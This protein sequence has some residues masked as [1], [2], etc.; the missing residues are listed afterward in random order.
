MHVSMRHFSKNDV[1]LIEGAQNLL[2]GDVARCHLGKMY[3]HVAPAPKLHERCMNL[4]MLYL[5]PT[6]HLT[7]SCSTTCS[8]PAQVGPQEALTNSFD[9]VLR[10]HKPA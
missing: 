9:P 4:R 2:C 8:T 5:H 6:R 7:S 1:R 3:Y 10:K